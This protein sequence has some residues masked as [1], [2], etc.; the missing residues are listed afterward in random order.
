MAD[1]IGVLGCALGAFFGC[2]LLM[3]HLWSQLGVHGHRLRAANQHFSTHALG[4][5]GERE[6]GHSPDVPCKSVRRA[7]Y[8]RIIHRLRGKN[9]S[10]LCSSL[11]T[12][13]GSTG[14]E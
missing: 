6:K 10:I 5:E 11:A 4:T 9:P 12:V 13:I 14:A 8:R 2:V 1:F 3:P 7:L